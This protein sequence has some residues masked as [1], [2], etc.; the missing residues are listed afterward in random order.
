M[1]HFVIGLL[2]GL[3]SGVA[4]SGLVVVAYMYWQSHYSPTCVSVEEMEDWIDA[5]HQSEM[6]VTIPL[7][8]IAEPENIEREIRRR[9]EVVKEINDEFVS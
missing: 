2:V 5:N 4:I 7:I 6:D 8:V 1:E 3:L 9:S